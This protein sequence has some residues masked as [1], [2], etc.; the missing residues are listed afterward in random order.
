MLSALIKDFCKTL[1]MQMKN[2]IY[3]LVYVSESD[4][5]LS[6]SYTLEITSKSPSS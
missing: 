3:E 1:K 6:V 2:Y 5:F 4:C